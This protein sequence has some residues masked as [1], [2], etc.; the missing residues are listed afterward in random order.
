MWFELQPIYEI[1]IY[2]PLY[3]SAIVII[4]YSDS[5]SYNSCAISSI[6]I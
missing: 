3:Y 2:C 4:G 1:W 6:I 5:I